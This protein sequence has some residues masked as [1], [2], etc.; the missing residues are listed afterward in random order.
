MDEKTGLDQ[1][2]NYHDYESNFDEGQEN[3]ILNGERPEIVVKQI[4]NVSDDEY[5]EL[6]NNA[7]P[8]FRRKHLIK[9]I[10][11]TPSE[12][13]SE[14][15]KWV[16][17]FIEVF[18]KKWTES[19]DNL[20]Y[21]RYSICVSLNFKKIMVHSLKLFTTVFQTCCMLVLKIYKMFQ[22]T[23]DEHSKFSPLKSLTV[24]K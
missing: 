3:A 17:T 19:F 11:S 15:S 2:T 24:A 14:R 23:Q 18:Q 12:V 16:S 13:D 21:I 9:D 4:R 6:Y 1:D 7:T 8:D 20:G 5:R 22:I 10:D